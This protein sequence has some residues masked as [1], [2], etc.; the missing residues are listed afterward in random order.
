MNAR[1]NFMMIEGSTNIVEGSFGEAGL[2]S[3]IKTTPPVLHENGD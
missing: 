2:E 1:V 3:K